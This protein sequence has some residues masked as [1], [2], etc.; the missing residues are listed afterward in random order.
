MMVISFIAIIDFYFEMATQGIVKNP[1][2]QET[3]CV[4]DLYFAL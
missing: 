3:S 4:P 2:E 1:I